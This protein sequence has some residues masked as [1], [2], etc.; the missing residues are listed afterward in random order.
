MSLSIALMMMLQVGPAGQA[1]TVD[2]PHD[3]VRDRPPRVSGE[4]AAPP[5]QPSWLAECFELVDTDP[6]RANS[7]AQIKRDSSVGTDRILANHCLGL[8][9]TKMELWDQAQTAFIAARNEVPAAE[10][11]LRARMGAMAGNAALAKG[12]SATAL[13]LFNASRADARASNSGDLAAL[14]ALDQ[15]R[16]LV[17]LDRLAEVEP[18]LK[19]ARTL[20][21]NDPESRLLSATFYRRQG[22]LNDA[23][24]QIEQALA[25]SPLDPEISLE[26]G[27][28]AVL[29]G[30]DG[31]ARDSWQSVVATSP[32]HPAA[33]TAR[34]Y[35][36]QLG[37]AGQ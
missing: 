32:D 28:I 20:R 12:D 2:D 34:T 13:V 9:A 36:D 6:A 5:S 25:L 22:Q 14:V 24:V 37:P 19:E 15:A 23:Q 35:L 8:A 3:L 30:N 17:S 33:A 7:I 11:P 21:P 18:L 16:V 1:G 4:I 29:L 10:L 26:A 27:V 31:T